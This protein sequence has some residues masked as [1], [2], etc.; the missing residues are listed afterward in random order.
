MS[1][2]LSATEAV[3]E[4]DTMKVATP[5]TTVYYAAPAAQGKGNGSSEANAT[6]FDE[7]VE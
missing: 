1:R 7:N 4:C 3:D 6:Y 5:I 2:A